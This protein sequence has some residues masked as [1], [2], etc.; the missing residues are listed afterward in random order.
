MQD[1]KEVH[2]VVDRAYQPGEPL[3][4]WC[5]P[6][7]NSRLLINYGIVDESNPCDKL[8]LSSEACGMGGWLIEVV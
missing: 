5:G 6:Q 1:S 3:V 4:A 2:L 8:P 7:P